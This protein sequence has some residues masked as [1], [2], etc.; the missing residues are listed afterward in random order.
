LATYKPV[1]ELSTMR[2]WSLLLQFC[3]A[4]GN[5]YIHTHKPAKY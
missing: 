2:T 5:V 3:S 4:T 1:N